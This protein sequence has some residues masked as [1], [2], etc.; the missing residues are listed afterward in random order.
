MVG[1]VV[2]RRKQL[3]K[4]LQAQNSRTIPKSIYV[5]EASNTK[6]NG[7]P[8]PVVL[9]QI[10]RKSGVKAS[11]IAV[12]TNTKNL[13]ADAVR[14]QTIDQLSPEFTHIIYN[15]R[16]QEGWD[17]PSV[18]V[19]YFDGKTD[20]ATRI[21]QVIGRALRQPEAKHLSDDDLNTAFFY[22][23]CPNETLEHIVDELK[24]ELRIYK[25]DDEP[26]DF[27]PFQIKEVKKIV[28]RIP[29]RK[30]YVG[31]LTV[32]NLQLELPP[33]DILGKLLKKKT[34]DFSEEERSAPGKA[35]ISIVSVKTGDVKQE[36]RDLCEDMRVRCGTYLHQQV[37]ALS[38]DCANAMKPDLFTNEKLDKTAC[39]NSKAL[40]HYRELAMTLVEAYENHVRLAELADPAER[41]YTVGPY[42]PSAQGQKAFTHSAHPYYDPKALNDGELKMAKAFDKFP[43]Y[44][45]A[46]NKARLDY[47]IP[48]P[49]KGGTSATFY[50][51]FLWWVKKTVWAIDPTGKF[52]LEEKI[53]TKLF[54]VPAPLQI[55][56]IT[57]GK[58]DGNH[59]TDDEGW[60]LSRFRVGS[61]GPELF[62]DLQELLD[63]LVEES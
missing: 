46:R 48:L 3:E 8:R 4:A 37:R 24:E 34:F 27:E 32:P 12:C 23:N 10:L 56:L 38:R 52:I 21:Q 33:H 11:Q 57:P 51:D 61:T 60:T 62:D 43:K 58:Y 31:K 26:D 17:D 39:F 53:R 28:P 9:W 19:C 42:Q 18:Y 20:S 55:A 45:W 54:A 36:S 15:K 49:K 13:P 50:P 44:V 30:E 29:V 1:D 2:K 6:S 59:Q 5:V 47:G 40:N 16:L 22:I 14:V 7:E 41:E 63:T 35:V 25:G